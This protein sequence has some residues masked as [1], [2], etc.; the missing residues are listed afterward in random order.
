MQPAASRHKPSFERKRVAFVCCNGWLDGLQ[1][2]VRGPLRGM[3]VEV[4]LLRVH[5]PADNGVASNNDLDEFES[6]VRSSAKR[7]RDCHDAEVDTVRSDQPHAMGWQPRFGNPMSTVVH[8]CPSNF[9]LYSDPRRPNFYRSEAT[10]ARSHRKPRRFGAWIGWHLRARD[11]VLV[12]SPHNPLRAARPGKT[13]ALMCGR[14]DFERQADRAG[15]RV[16]RSSSWPHPCDRGAAGLSG[17]RSRTRGGAW[18][19]NGAAC[20]G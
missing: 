13:A 8:R 1:R 10:R 4:K 20:A 14:A 7:L 3:Q 11:R 12:L 15:G 17:C 9:E 6:G 18:R 2:L 5:H 16:C 19:R